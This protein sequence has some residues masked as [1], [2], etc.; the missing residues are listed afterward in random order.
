MMIK[1]YQTHLNLVASKTQVSCI[2]PS[3]GKLI[4]QAWEKQ[5]NLI[6]WDKLARQVTLLTLT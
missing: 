2:L 5:V 4:L 3:L 6:E 1:L